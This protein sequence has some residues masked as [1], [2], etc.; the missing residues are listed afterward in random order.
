MGKLLVLELRPGCNTY[1]LNELKNIEIISVSSGGLLLSDKS[2]HEEVDSDDE[3][4]W[5]Y[6]IENNRI[7]FSPIFMSILDFEETPEI[8]KIIYKKTEVY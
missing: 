2:D 8:V 3:L 5:D 4:D 7:K 1:V 6:E